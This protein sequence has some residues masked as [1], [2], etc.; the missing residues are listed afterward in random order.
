M[1]TRKITFDPTSGVPYAANFNIYGGAHLRETFN[2]VTTSNTA[3]NLTGYTPSSQ[4]RKWAGSVG[5]TTTF[6]CSVPTPATQ[7]KILLSLS[8]T[9]TKSLTPGRHVYDVI[10]TTDA[11]TVQKV[12]EGSVLIREGVTR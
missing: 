10:L 8:A 12:V 11:G 7:G 4:V 9:E 6:T 2:V 1:S 5:V 3:F